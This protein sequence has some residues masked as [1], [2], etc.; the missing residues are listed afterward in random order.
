MSERVRRDAA[1]HAA[2]RVK[3]QLASA[4]PVPNARAK[5]KDVQQQRQREENEKDASS[6]VVSAHVAVM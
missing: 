3:Q 6:D 1:V 5:R 2:A 4:R